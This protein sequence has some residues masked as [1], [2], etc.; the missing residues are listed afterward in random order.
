M[1]FIDILD[2]PTQRLGN[3]WRVAGG[4]N[5]MLFE[6]GSLKAQVDITKAKRTPL[7]SVFEQNKPVKLAGS[8]S[9]RI[10]HCTSEYVEW[11]ETFQRNGYVEPITLQGY[12]E[13][14]S[15]SIGR[16]EVRLKNVYLDV[17][18]L[19]ILDDQSD[20]LAVTDVNF[21]FDGVELIEKF[22]TPKNFR[23]NRT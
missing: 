11:A 1:P 5:R 7:G 6:L 12:N 13:D 2:T 16:Q 14:P 17:V 10:Y 18:P 19:I 3:A 23:G 21:T 4:Q 8:G 22:Q 9:M 20:E 15:T